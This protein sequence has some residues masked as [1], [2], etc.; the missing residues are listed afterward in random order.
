M[1]ELVRVLASVVVASDCLLTTSGRHAGHPFSA[2]PLLQSPELL[3]RLKAKDTTERK[4]TM[5]K[6]TNV[7]LM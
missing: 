1:A 3:L 2:V 6:A 4:E 7:P 5:S